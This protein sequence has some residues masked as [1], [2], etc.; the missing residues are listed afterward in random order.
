MSNFKSV[1]EKSFEGT[2]YAWSDQMRSM[3]GKDFTVLEIREDGI[4]GL[5]SPNGQQNGKWFFHQRAVRKIEEKPGIL[6]LTLHPCLIKS[7]IYIESLQLWEHKKFIWLLETKSTTEDGNIVALEPTDEPESTNEP[8]ID[9][10]E[11]TPL[12]VGALPGPPGNAIDIDP[13]GLSELTFGQLL[14]LF[15]KIDKARKEGN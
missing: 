7:I 14:V 3:L 5:P 11:N 1:V 12:D 15:S 9:S 6:S 10:E 13:D 8:V 2:P 4:I